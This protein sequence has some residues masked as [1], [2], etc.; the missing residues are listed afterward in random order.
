MFATLIS[1]PIVSLK[2]SQQNFLMI[3]RK[4]I[5]HTIQSLVEAILH[6]INFIFC[7]SKNVQ[8]NAM[9]PAT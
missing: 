8:N 5:E 4:I 6:I 2:I 3:F 9:T 1:F 7:W